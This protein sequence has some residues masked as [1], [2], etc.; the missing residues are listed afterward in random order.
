MELTV[1]CHPAVETYILESALICKRTKVDVNKQESGRGDLYTRQCP[2][3]SK[4]FHG[5]IES[6]S[7]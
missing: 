7:C 3:L 1:V 5:K 4:E 2:D 6:N